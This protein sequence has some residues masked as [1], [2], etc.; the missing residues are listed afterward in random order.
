MKLLLTHTPEMRANYYGE[1][2]LSGLRS[3]V[4]VQLHEA[5]DALAPHALIAVAGCEGRIIR[6]W[7][8]TVAAAP[9]P[10]P[11]LNTELRACAASKWS[12]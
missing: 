11:R 9:R 10:Q 8:S 1:R 4:E 6:Q 12:L 2:A 5:N 7:R 3:L